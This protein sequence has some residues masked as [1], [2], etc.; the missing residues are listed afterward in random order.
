MAL[1]R[2]DRGWRYSFQRQKQRITSKRYKTKKDAEAALAEHKKQV[3]KE[4]KKPT[5]ITFFDLASKYLDWSEKRHVKKTYEYK[6]MVC[7]E[8]IAHAGGVTLTEQKALPNIIESY[9]NTRPTNHNFN[10]HRKE[11]RSVFNFGIDKE[12]IPPPNP[13]K[14]I[15][16]LPEDQPLKYIP[17]QE[18]LI[19]VLL[20]AG[21]DRPFLEVILNTLGRVS[22]ILSLRWCDVNLSHRTIRLWTRKRKG[23]GLESDDLPMNDELYR[24]LKGLWDSRDQEEWV[25]YNKDTKTRYNRRPKLM[26]GICK[27]AGVKPFGFHAIR[28]FA[29]S[30]LADQD[31]ISMK[32]ISGLLRHKSLNTT[33]R[34]LH[35]VSES[36]KTAIGTLSELKL[37]PAPTPNKTQ[38]AT[39]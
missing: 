29:A 16:K 1:W 15:D 3:I 8:F 20:A 38:G 19:K 14:K 24:V 12:L 11:L 27:R 32:T 6:V 37:L 7:R 30:F 31:K 22:E 25:F 39:E 4:A 18:D 36:Q 9:L 17:S 35:H 13:I 34:Y 28:H 2:D 21:D 33:E 10:I 23:G 26:S 5:G